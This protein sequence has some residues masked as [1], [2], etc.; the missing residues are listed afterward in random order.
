[1]KDSPAVKIYCSYLTNPTKFEI[2]SLPIDQA[3]MSNMYL[4]RISLK[5]VGPIRDLVFDMP[6]EGDKPTPLVLVG[7]NGSGKTTVISFIVNAMIGMKQHA[8]E[9]AEVYAG[10][11]YRVRSTLA[12]NGDSN[13]YFARLDFDGNAS[14]EQSP[15]GMNRL[16]I[17]ESAFL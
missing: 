8:F 1:M 11:V 7:P 15:N 2:F 3:R 13:F 5:N 17:P 14:L 9:E 10:K 12:I 6:F 16:R 4:R